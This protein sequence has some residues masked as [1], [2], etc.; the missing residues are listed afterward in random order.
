VNDLLR[1]VSPAD[2]KDELGR[3]PVW[4]ADA[5][6]EAVCRARAAFPA[7]RDAGFEA[8]AAAIRRFRD[9]VG[10]RREELAELIAREVGKALWE[11]RAEVDLLPAK[12]DLT[13][14]AGM[15]F[16]QPMR[17]GANAWASFHPRGV[18]AVLGPFDFPAHLPSGHIIPALATGNA[19][20]FKPSEM[21]PAVGDF[22]ARLWRDA[23]LPLGV[24]EMVQGRAE[25]G[26]QLAL[27]PGVDGILFSGSYSVGR[28]LQE[29]LLDQPA[30]ILALEMGG[31]NAMIVLDDAELDLAVSEA[32]ISICATTGQRCSS[33][34]RIF[35]AQSRMEEFSSRL[36][37]VLSGVRIGA[38]LEPDVFMGP[39]ISRAAFEKVMRY[40]G[41]AAA[42][43]GDRIFRGE[44]DRLAPY[45][46]PS[47]VRFR[48]TEQSHPYQRDEIFGPE[49]ALYPVAG[50]DAA[51]AAVNDAD[52]GLAA[53]VMSRDRA[54]F[55][56]CIGRIRTGVLNWNRGTIGASGALPFGGAGRSGNDR[57][58]GILS[59][60]YCTYPQ[61]HLE[62]D[63][64]FDPEKLPRGMPRP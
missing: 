58:A 16:T 63:G 28:S 41:Q 34:S 35:V 44:M 18:L 3:F 49:A 53:S 26:H 30:K 55:E 24:L 10:A 11:A 56:H 60:V 54:N 39:L 12:A 23:G 38:P 25:T 14:T 32:A 2:P 61:A 21:A 6:D 19:I 15:R 31:K 46:A 45:I 5:V 57:P 40:R 8:R 27:H 22:L 33:L 36:S 51:I 47:L 48:K 13:L 29:E 62:N 1:S 50:L 59:T 9:L 7:W 52:Y 17:G 20:V 42:A 43:G 37:R 64:G 4:D